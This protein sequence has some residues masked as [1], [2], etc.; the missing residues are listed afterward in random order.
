MSEQAQSS[1]GAGTVVTTSS[2]SLLVLPL[3]IIGRDDLPVAG[4]KGANLGELVRA[5][6]PV[7][8]GFVVTTAAY[9]RFV[10]ESHLGEI[11][12]Q[13]LG[14]QQ[15]GSAAIRGAFEHAAIPTEIA[16]AIMEAYQQLGQG[17][18]AVRSSATAEDL[19]GAAFAGQQDTFLNIVG[20]EGLLDAVRRCWASLWTDRA[21]AYRERQR[22]DQQ[23]VKLAVVVQRMVVAEVA[24][25]LFTANPVTGTR[26]EIVI[27]A[28][29][30]LG[31]AV[32]DDLVPRARHRVSGKQHTCDLRYHHA[33]NHNR[34]LHRLLIHSLAFAVS[35]S[36]VGPERCPAAPHSI[37]QPLSANDI[38]EGVLL[39]SKC[40][41][42]QILC[43]R[44][45]A[46][47]TRALSELLVCLHDRLCNLC[48]DGRVLKCA[49][50][51]GTATLLLPKRLRNY[52]TQVA[53][54]HEAVISRRGYNEA[55]GNWE[56]C[57]D[58]FA[59]VSALA[60]CHRKIITPND[61][62]W[63]DKQRCAAGGNHSPCSATRLGLFAH[64]A[65]SS[66]SS[67]LAFLVGLLY[68]LI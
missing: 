37:Q 58:Q 3:N 67:S 42:W 49:P 22:M 17:P 12:T 63:E 62:Q 38:E 19:P 23:T 46:H 34:Q 8:N 26:N 48:R 2:T 14:E 53:L 57:A 30:G 45:R 25:V 41:P 1:G 7:P 61:V 65:P 6:F 4:G 43:R 11:I 20:R 39:A 68:A 5:G 16:Q 29:P 13:A 55:I 44:A 66:R 54:R 9:D 59:Q 28:N 33:L 52:F 60:T 10:A 21:I 50:D 51:G 18:V 36:T 24:G 31:E 32:D 56:A 35:N 15:G 27:D 47:G 64:R 40:R